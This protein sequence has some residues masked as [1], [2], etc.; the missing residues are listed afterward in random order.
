MSTNM[1]VICL[2]LSCGGTYTKRVPSG[3]DVA[4]NPLL[5]VGNILLGVL[6]VLVDVLAVAVEHAWLWWL[7]RLNWHRPRAVLDTS[8]EVAG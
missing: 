6:E 7:A 2:G 5:D 1:S 4:L 8:S 3:L